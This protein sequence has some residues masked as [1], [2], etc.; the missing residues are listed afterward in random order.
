MTVEEF[1]SHIAVI[2]LRYRGSCISWGRSPEHNA[3]VGGHKD[4][5][6]MT[7]EAA[8]L[9]FET[10]EEMKLACS[11]AKRQGLW[12]KKNG[13]LTVHFQSLRPPD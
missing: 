12:W 5:L 13:R 4:S 7:W 10:E 9:L 11:R 3:K 8:D 1:A 2:G 6:H